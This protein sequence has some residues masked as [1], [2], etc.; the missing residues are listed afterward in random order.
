[1]PGTS[2]SV[3]RETPPIPRRKFIKPGEPIGPK[4]NVSER[5]TVQ[6]LTSVENAIAERVA[7]APKEQA[8]VPFTLDELDDL[9]QK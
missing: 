3:E 1:M 6:Q 5:L 7:K 4:L 9:T 2:S 8:Q